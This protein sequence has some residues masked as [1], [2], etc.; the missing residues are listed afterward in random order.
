ME[1]ALRKQKIL[2]AVIENFIHTGEPVG[3][4][5]LQNED[6]FNVSSATIRNDMADLTGKGY[7][8][9]PHTSAGR[10]PTQQGYRYYIDNIM[11]VEPLEQGQKEYIQNALYQN[12][13]SPENI[14]K[15]ASKLLSDTTNLVSL[16][17]TPSAKESRIHKIS[18]VQTGSHTAMAVVI[19]SNGVIKNKLFRC[20]FII[21]PEILQVFDK[22]L[23]DI[24]EGVKLSSI[25]RPF[26]QTA[27]A[28][29][30]EL[31]LLI[32]SVLMAIK[33]CADSARQE[34]VCISGQKNLLFMSDLNFLQARSIM[35]FLGNSQDLS[36]M[37]ENLPQETAV[38]IGN[39]N[40][41]I[42]L[43]QT[44]VVSTRYNVEDSATGVLAVVAPTRI[45]YSKTI[46]VLECI[47]DCAGQLIS[48]LVEI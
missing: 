27:A 4:K 16:A 10:I 40:M 47:G 43:K 18:F 20:E 15:G 9:Q 14:L 11:N 33:D 21:T 3:S 1:L 19:A 12:A 6:E 24:F 26:I 46:S 22:A 35:E 34:N 31:S 32:P 39:E 23:N 48:E 2:S 29:F 5:T 17:T 28:R 41:R 37:L 45:D 30:G 8:V 36:A 7:L 42:E 38:S 13:D 44:S 25:N